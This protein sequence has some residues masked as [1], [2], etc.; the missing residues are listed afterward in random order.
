MVKC[1]PLITF[2]AMLYCTYTRLEGL[3][4]FLCSCA[5]GLATQS[6]GETTNLFLLSVHVCCCLVHAYAVTVHETV[7][8]HCNSMCDEE[9]CDGVKLWLSICCVRMLGHWKPSCN[10][11]VLVQ[12]GRGWS[13]SLQPDL[14]LTVLI[15]HGMMYDVWDCKL[16]TEEADRA[17]IA[18]LLICR[19]LFTVLL[20][21]GLV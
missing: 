15:G 10:L 1:M 17:H 18:T 8:V 7:K 11:V 19:C 2:S 16:L 5:G 13:R 4:T 9:K 12:Q 14:G 6:R 3:S 20:L 21:H